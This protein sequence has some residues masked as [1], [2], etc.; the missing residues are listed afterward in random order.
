MKLE[1]KKEFAKNDLLKK[2]TE[3]LVPQ[4]G[5]RAP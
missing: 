2:E 3:T 5:T 1:T 4:S